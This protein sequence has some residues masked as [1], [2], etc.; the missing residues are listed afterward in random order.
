MAKN[1]I[2][3][4]ESNR[5]KFGIAP[6]SPEGGAED[7]IGSEAGRDSKGG[8]CVAQ[9]QSNDCRWQSLCKLSALPTAPPARPH[10]CGASWQDKETPRQ[11]PTETR[12]GLP[13]KRKTPPKSN[14]QPQALFQGPFIHRG[15]V[16]HQHSPG[17]PPLGGYRSCSGAARAIRRFGR[18]GLSKPCRPGRFSTFRRKW[19]PASCSRMVSLSA[20]GQRSSMA[21][22]RFRRAR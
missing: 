11:A 21:M 1:L 10:S 16:D 2:F 9:P 6:Y 17:S 19:S 22:T 12:T 5:E 7:Y 13:S 15:I 3:L 4:I 20:A 14:L 8:R 18:K